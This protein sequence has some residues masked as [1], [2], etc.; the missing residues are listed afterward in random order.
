MPEAVA[1]SFWHFDI[2]RDAL[3]VDRIAA[4]LRAETDNGFYIKLNDTALFH[5]DGQSGTTS[6]KTVSRAAGIISSEREQFLTATSGSRLRRYSPGA[7]AVVDSMTLKVMPGAEQTGVLDSSDGWPKSGLSARA[8]AN[9]AVEAALLARLAVVSPANALSERI[10]AWPDMAVEITDD[11]GRVRRVGD[12][13][14]LTGSSQP[15]RLIDITVELPRFNVPNYHGPYASVWLSDEHHHLVKTLLLRGG[16]NRWLKELR[17]WWRKI[18]RSQP[19]LIDA[20]AGA[21]RKNK[22]LH[23]RWDGT[24]EQGN[25]V[26]ID[27]LTL[28]VEIAREDGGRNVLN[29]PLT[30]DALNKGT[31]TV[32]GEGEIGVVRIASR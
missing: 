1:E 8:L 2:I 13:Q 21:T 30:A 27:E 31:F 15:N 12:F 22:P 3:T 17:V 18:G 6:Q 11:K 32:E 9:T 10:N 16:N 4:R 23:I 28:N 20:F 29:I 5:A 14:T 25:P 7:E 24:D 19:D 26:T